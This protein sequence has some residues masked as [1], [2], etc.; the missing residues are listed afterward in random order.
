MGEV[1]AIKPIIEHIKSHSFGIS[2]I[3]DTGFENARKVTQNVRYLPFEI[4]LPFWLK[5][6]KTLVVVEAELWFMLFYLLKSRGAKTILLNARI[7]KGSLKNYKRFAFLYKKIFENIDVVFAQDEANA[8]RLT[9]IGAK[10]VK[11]GG[12]LKL[13][14]IAK[15]TRIYKKPESK[16]FIIAAS[17]HQGEEEIVL[18]AFKEVKNG[19][20]AIAPRH[21]N[22]FEEVYEKSLSFAK[23]HGLSVVRFTQ[24]SSFSAD[25]TLID[26]MGELNNLYAISDVVILGGAFGNAGGH[27]PIE[28]AS[29][30]CKII[31][32]VNIFHQLPLFEAIE[33][34]KLCLPSELPSILAEHEKLKRSHIK[35][36]IDLRTIL[37]EMGV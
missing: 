16:I 34:Y 30:N 28:P 19:V 25:I 36:S 6:H 32:G 15:P 8:S 21:P 13:L 22:R 29:F 7:S 1:N 10:N 31:S 14:N 9:E 12:N 26:T 3:T 11:I 18:E 23:K 4:F 24:D 17:T 33:N 20:F 2:V 35:E 37:E 5:R 27:N